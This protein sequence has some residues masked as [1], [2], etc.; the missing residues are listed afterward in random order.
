MLMYASCGHAGRVEDLLHGRGRLGA[1]RRVLEEDRVPD[2]Q[3]RAGEAGH[4]V[5]GVVP[6]HDPEQEADRAAPDEGRALAVEQLDRLVGQEVRRVVGVVPVDRRAEVDLVER[7]LDRLAHLA[8]DDPR[9]LVPPLGVQLG[10]AGDDL[11][12]LLDAR[13]STPAPVRVVRPADRG[14]QRVVADRLEGLQLLPGRGVGDGVL[15]GAHALLVGSTP[16]VWRMRITR[17]PARPWPPS[18]GR[19]TGRRRR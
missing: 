9:E 14:L 13:A 19:G 16:Q 3:V 2:H 18:P 8:R 4:L 15:D 6:R 5:V 11:G 10:D 7:L 12:P 1:L 17:V